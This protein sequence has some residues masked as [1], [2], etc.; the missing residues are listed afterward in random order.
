MFMRNKTVSTPL[1]SKSDIEK[2]GE[3]FSPFPWEQFN[4]KEGIE[5]YCGL[6]YVFSLYRKYLLSLPVDVAW[7]DRPDFSF[8]FPGFSVGLEVTKATMNRLEHAYAVQKKYFPEGTTR[9]DLD[10]CRSNDTSKPTA[11]Q[12]IQPIEEPFQ[13][14]GSTDY[15]DEKLW[16]RCIGHSIKQK[17]EALNNFGF[18][19]FTQNELIILDDSG[20]I[21]GKNFDL[22]YALARVRRIYQARKGPAKLLYDK[23]HVTTRVYSVIGDHQITRWCLLHD[24][25]GDCRKIVYRIDS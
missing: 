8:S 22:V 16:I 14:S 11:L 15:S 20:A 2:I 24:L 4:E 19:K 9:I 10:K 3:Y 7:D 6:V 5:L 23:I 17:T 21:S 25:L 12:A 13:D 1:R 18:K